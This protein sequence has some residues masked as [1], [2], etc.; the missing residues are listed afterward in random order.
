MV[1]I[2]L[3]MR[4]KGIPWAARTSVKLGAKKIGSSAVVRVMMNV[5][6]VTWTAET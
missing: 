2:T 1:M 6:V 3:R 4:E 5:K